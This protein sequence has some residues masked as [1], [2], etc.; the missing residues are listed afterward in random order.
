[1]V[2]ICISDFEVCAPV[3]TV[4]GSTSANIFK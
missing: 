3:F 1:L 2:S 4:T